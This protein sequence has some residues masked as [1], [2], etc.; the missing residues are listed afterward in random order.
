VNA[1]VGLAEWADSPFVAGRLA[2]AGLSRA[3]AAEKAQ[4]FARVAAALQR[5]SAG[6]PVRAFVVPGRIEVLG[7]HTD[8]AGGRSLLA[9]TEQGFCLLVASRND[10][11]IRLTDA[12]TG[13]AAEFP[14]APDLATQPGHWSHYSKT[15]ARRVASNFSAP[16]AGA[17]IAFAS[18]LPPAAGMSSSSAL[19]VAVFLAISAVNDLTHRD[20][21]RRNIPTTEALAGYLGAIENGQDFGELRG[22]A[23]VGTFGGS[24]DHTAILCCRAGELS[25]YSFCPVRAESITPLPEP[26][27][28]AVAAGGVVAEKTGQTKEKYNRASR[29]AVAAAKCWR[30]ATGDQAPHLG[31]AVAS[32]PTAFAA[33]RKVLQSRSAEGF[34]PSELVDRAD[35]FYAESEEIV[36]AAVDALQRSDFQRFG[37]LADRSQHLAEKLLKNQVP[38]TAYLARSAREL[39]ATAASAFG[40]GFGGAVWALVES[41]TAQGF[42]AEWDQA[43]CRTFPALEERCRFF[44]T[45]PAPAAFELSPGAGTQ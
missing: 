41:G 20:I 15:V 23:G 6:G 32:G 25:G 7:K 16:L 1:P 45:C 31:A 44:L 37:Q 29:L 42:L 35:Q 38:E 28:L 3:A 34:F 10:S 11:T 21:Y 36:P 19:V 5:I 2:S 8:Y 4:L 12:T 22:D 13:E 43:Y 33:L 9:A 17:D 26:W 39:G 27:V 14:I 30:E 18:D 24:E 40:A